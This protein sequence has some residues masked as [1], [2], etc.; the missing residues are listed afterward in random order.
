MSKVKILVVEDEAII[1]DNISDTLE[2]LGYDVLEPAYNYSEAIAL[3]EAERPDIAIL[4]IQLAGKKSGVD[5][6][7]KINQ[8][9]NFPFIFLSSN[10]DKLTLEQAKSVEPFAYL[11]KP[12]VKEELYT[13]IEVALYNYSKQSEKALNT[14]NL[15]IQNALFIKEN[16]AFIRLNF[17]EIVYLQSDHIYIDIYLKCGRKH[18]VRGSLNEYMSKLG[19][20]FFRSHRSYIVNLDFLQELK[21]SKIVLENM[22]IPIGQN[23]REE[24]LSRLNRG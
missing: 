2:E 20:V 12:F 3:I 7:I 23:Q 13:S 10:T 14:E 15:V 9:Y 18:S 22:E 1:A 6:A 4:D 17:D 11:V 19:N 24:L 5:L 21:Q 8:E 16:K